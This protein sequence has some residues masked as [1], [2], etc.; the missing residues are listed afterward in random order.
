MC[1]YFK[2]QVINDFHK[3]IYLI[4]NWAKEL[5]ICYNYHDFEIEKVKKDA[6]KYKGRKFIYKKIYYY[7]NHMH[8]CSF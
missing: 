8:A 2:K 1:R 4:G 6:D 7:I 3:C 5:F